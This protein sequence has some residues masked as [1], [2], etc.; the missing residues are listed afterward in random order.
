MLVAGVV[1]VALRALPPPYGSWLAAHPLAGRATFGVAMAVTAASIVYSPWGARSGAHLNPAV[2]L[3][4]AYLGKLSCGDAFAYV[5]AQ[6]AGGAAGF[7]VIS[8]VAGNALVA[9]PTHAI[10]TKPGPYGTGA[11][12]AAE[13]T[14]S[15]LLM[16]VVLTV[17]NASKRISRFTGCAAA[18]LVA[19]FITFEAPL[20]GMSM[21]PARTLASGLQGR[22]FTDIWLYFAAPPLGMLVAAFVFTKLRGRDAVRCGRLNH[23][24]PGP[25]PFVCTYERLRP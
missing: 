23:A 2:T 17:S 24:A 15:F 12:F 10:V 14:M 11:A 4:F 3:T 1:A 9:P 5:V 19:L 16:S 25:C 22:D 18:T 7:F 21:N 6:F 8:A 20:S 13:A